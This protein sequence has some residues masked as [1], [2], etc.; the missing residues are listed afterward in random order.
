MDPALEHQCGVGVAQVMK[1][2]WRQTSVPK[3]PAPP[4]RERIWVYRLA[5][6]EPEWCTALPTLFDA[7]NETPSQSTRYNYTPLL[8]LTTTGCAPDPGCRTDFGL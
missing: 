8:E 6:D 4:S 1:P 3:R 7:I 5:I 2:D